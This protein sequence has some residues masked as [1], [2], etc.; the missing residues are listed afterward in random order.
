MRS[1]VEWLEELGLEQYA[2]RF[3]ENGID[4]SVLGRLSDQDL[5]DLGV[6]WSSAQAAGRDCRA[7]ARCFCFAQDGSRAHKPSQ[8]TQ[9]NAVSSP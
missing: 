2:H 5:K 4:F 1:I 6:A 9:L 3:A 8:R 7:S